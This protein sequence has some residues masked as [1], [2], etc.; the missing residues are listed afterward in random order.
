MSR[1]AI[2]ARAYPRPSTSPRL[3]PPIGGYCVRGDTMKSRLNA[4]PGLFGVFLLLIGLAWALGVP[5]GAGPDEHEHY[6]KALAVGG[7]DLYGRPPRTRDPSPEQLERFLKISPEDLA[8]LNALAE[9]PPTT[10]EL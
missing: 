6:I 2:T 10:G 4:A 1:W 3:G 5:P 7:G 9:E 8:K